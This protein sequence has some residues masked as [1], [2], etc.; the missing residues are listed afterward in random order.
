MPG[1]VGPSLLTAPFVWND[2]EARESLQRLEAI[3]AT[4][5]LPGHGEPWTGS[6][7]EAVRLARLH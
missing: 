5:M 3:D 7:A 2:G 1:Y 6:I 4:I